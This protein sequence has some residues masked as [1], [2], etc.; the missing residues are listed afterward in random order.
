MRENSIPTWIDHF[1]ITFGLFFK[2]TLGAHPFIWKLVFIH[3]QMKTNFHMKRWAPGLALKK[4]PKVIR[5]WS[6]T[7]HY[8]TQDSYPP[9]KV[10]K[11]ERKILCLNRRYFSIVREVLTY[12]SWVERPIFLETALKTSLDSKSLFPS[13]KN[14][15]SNSTIVA[16]RRKIELSLRWKRIAQQY[17][18]GS[19]RSVHRRRC[20]WANTAAKRMRMR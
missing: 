20:G 11:Q 13:A 17:H 5:K 9:E 6:I 1:R 4:R 12:V 18:V 2:A 8:S 14:V 3:M 7:Y 10:R 16:K 19:R 15:K